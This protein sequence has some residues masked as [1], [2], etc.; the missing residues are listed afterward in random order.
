MTTTK[1]TARR[2][3]AEFCPHGLNCLSDG[4]TLMVFETAE[5]RDEM[6]R[7]L[8]E[9]PRRSYI[10]EGVA[11]AITRKEASKT[12]RTQDLGT[13]Y[14]REVYGL[15]TSAGRNFFEVGTKRYGALL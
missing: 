3:Y 2:Y 14:E 1:K 10:A 13:E 9:N 12:Y 11:R 15:R 6:V 7:E 5:E 4:D 8:N